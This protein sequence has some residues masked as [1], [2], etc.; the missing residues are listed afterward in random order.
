VYKVKDNIKMVA[1]SCILRKSEIVVNDSWLNPMKRFCVNS[2]E[3]F[4]FENV[5]V[6][7]VESLKNLHIEDILSFYSSSF[8]C[9]LADI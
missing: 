4:R 2:S 9:D 6:L 7:S 1:H 8:A 5:V 3:P